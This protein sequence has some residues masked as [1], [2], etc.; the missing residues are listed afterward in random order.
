MALKTWFKCA[1]EKLAW[2]VDEL[3]ALDLPASLP[4]GFCH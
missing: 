3:K 4:R 1:W 2:L